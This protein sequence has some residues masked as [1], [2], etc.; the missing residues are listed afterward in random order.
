MGVD[1]WYAFQIY[2]EFQKLRYLGIQ[3]TL[4][5]MSILSALL[6]ATLLVDQAR[7]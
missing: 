4:V 1:K 6:E 5:L 2:D 7:Q 3:T